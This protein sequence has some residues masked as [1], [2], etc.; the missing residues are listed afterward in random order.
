[1]LCDLHKKLVEDTRHEAIVLDRVWK[2][3]K[4]LLLLVAD[5]A[6]DPQNALL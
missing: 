2:D 3:R 1:M 5:C 6:R 4:D